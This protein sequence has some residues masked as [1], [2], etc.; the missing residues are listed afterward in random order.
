MVLSETAPQAVGLR[1]DRT[2]L[3]PEENNGMTILSVYEAKV[4]INVECLEI[5]GF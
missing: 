5:V 3:K 1:L 2:F 4:R